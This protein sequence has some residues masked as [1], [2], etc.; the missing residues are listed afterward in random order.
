MSID[1]VKEVEEQNKQL[2]E[3]LEEIYP[4]LDAANVVLDNPLYS[5]IMSAIRE[6]ETTIR[7]SLFDEMGSR[8]F[9]SDYGHIRLNLGRQMGHTTAMIKAVE[10]LNKNTPYQ[11]AWG[12][13][14]ENLRGSIIHRAGNDGIDMNMMAESSFRFGFD[15]PENI[16]RKTNK[17]FVSSVKYFF[18]DMFSMAMT[19]RGT[20]EEDKLYNLWMELKLL[21]TVESPLLVALG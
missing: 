15:R 10:T 8:A 2:Q 6:K 3:Q 13:E 5:I 11:A 18:I 1:Y 7:D 9:F 4:R 17:S 20:P 16:V 14:T 21:T 12:V 19:G